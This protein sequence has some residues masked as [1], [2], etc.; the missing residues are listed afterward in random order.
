M[1]KL[2][3]ILILFFFI[4]IVG[5]IFA[6]IFYK[7]EGSACMNDPLGFAEKKVP[8]DG[9]NVFCT[10]TQFQGLKQTTY[11][12]ENVSNQRKFYLDVE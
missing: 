1:K 4:L 8:G 6:L 11:Y 10:C 5:F 9:S 2:D 12:S 3:L 7:S